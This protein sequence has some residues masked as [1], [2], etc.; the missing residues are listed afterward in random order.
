M[1]IEFSLNLRSLC[2]ERGSI[3]QVCR[4]IGIN[5][6][7]FN[8]YLS[9]QGL[10][11]AHNMRRIAK[12]F[13]LNESDLFKPHNLFSKT[14]LDKG[15]AK[16]G[17]PLDALSQAFNDQAKGLR[18]YLGFYH[19]HFRTPSWEGKIMRSL[20]WL[21]EKDGFVVTRSLERVISSEDSIRQRIRFDGLAAFRSSRIYVLESEQ[22]DSA[23]IVETIMFPAHRQQ[24]NYLRGMSL[25]VAWRPRL[26]PY[27]SRTI[28]KKISVRVSLREAIEDCG[29]FAQNSPRLDPTV[30]GFLG[31]GVPADVESGPM[32]DFF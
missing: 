1:S 24:V 27:S 4:E 5:R 17:S 25:G 6:Q 29:V 9:G 15:T 13:G 10:P 32:Q 30:R 22:S 3:A 12:Y 2:A 31:G 20:L 19:A 8:R 23:G 16:D 26:T 28:W 14:Y 7:Q 21:Y 11:A 18:R